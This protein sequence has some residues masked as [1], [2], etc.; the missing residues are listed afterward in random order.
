MDLSK[1]PQLQAQERA[2]LWLTFECNRGLAENTLQ[3]YARGLENFFR[4]CIQHKINLLHVGLDDIGVYINDLRHR[5][6]PVHIE[7][8]SSKGN[9]GLKNSTINQRLTAVR[10]FYDYLKEEDIVKRNPVRRGR[11]IHHNSYGG[12]RGLVPKIQ[13]FPWIPDEEQWERI[14]AVLQKHKLRDKLLFA[15]SYDGALRREEVCGLHISDFDVAYRLLSIRA[16]NT[17]S[18]RARGVSYSEGTGQ[19]LRLYLRDRARISRQPGALCLS[20][21]PRN[22]GQPLGSAIWSKTV[23]SI[24][25]EADVSFFTPHTLRHLRLTDLARAGVDLHDIA[26]FA[27]HRNIDTT[28]QYIHLSGTELAERIG[29]RLEQLNWERLPGLIQNGEGHA[30]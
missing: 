6:L 4:F 5:Q 21:S 25:Q 18:R 10:R 2:V 15:L 8:A 29:K 22:Y 1:Y 26:T 24:A 14:I 23:R 12:E 27:G 16:E 30:D 20:E 9:S 13:N 28:M 3:A 17:K 19:L 7:R 11:Y